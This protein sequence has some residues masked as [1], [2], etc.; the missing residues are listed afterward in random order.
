MVKVLVIGGG[1][2]GCAAAL[3]ASKAG[4]DVTLLEKN[5]VLLGTGLVGGIMR[6]NGRWTATEEMIALGSGELFQAT[7]RAARHT[8][9]EFPG[10]KHATLYDVGRIEPLVRKILLDNGI[11]IQLQTRFTDLEMDGRNIARVYARKNFEKVEY[12]ADI[13]VETTG[14]AGPQGNCKK[15][16]H[17]CAMCILRCPTFGP[18]VSVAAKA[19]V[20]ELIGGTRTGKP[21]AMSGSCKLYKH[22][23]S[24]EIIEQ[25]DSTGVAMVS[26]PPELQKKDVLPNKACQ[27]YA[28]KEFAENI[29]L[30][31]TGHA[32][33]MTSYFPIDIL[34]QLP[35]LE[36]ARYEDP[37]GG[38]I[39]NSV[40][41]L[42]ISPRDNYLQVEGV[43][44]LFCAGEKAG[45]L[46]GHTEAIVT[47]TLAGHNAVR[48]ALGLEL[49][50]LPETL[51]VGDAI[52]YVGEAIKTE[53][54]LRKKYTFSGASYLERMKSL[55]LYTTDKKVIEERVK[56]TGLTGVFSKPLLPAE[57]VAATRE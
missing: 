56:Q 55:G 51:T 54:G 40:R 27:Q 5:D 53:E 12:E 42:A 31:D 26:I 22:S 6:N 30:L 39:G 13:Y 32:K 34:R 15:Y 8:N 33:M 17:G 25:L 19:G 2:S 57:E 4:A 35:G 21:G 41:Y 36:N 46:V 38:S 24:P 43:D 49:L 37:Y 3:A 28:L 50:S 45:P 44:N 18:R 14:T 20:K 16:G 29:V 48:K 23:L 47:G 7:D 10:H 1:W 9:V 11:D 52:A